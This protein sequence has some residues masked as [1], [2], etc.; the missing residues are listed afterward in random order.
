MR[1]E[2]VLNNPEAEK[3]LLD[4]NGKKKERVTPEQHRQYVQD[5]LIEACGKLD[6]ESIERQY[7]RAVSAVKELTVV[8]QAQD[9]S[10]F[11]ARNVALRPRILGIF[12]SALVNAVRELE[13]PITLEIVKGVSLDYFGYRLNRKVT[14]KGSLGDNT[15]Y[16]MEDGKLVVEGDCKG[17]VGPF[18]RGGTI[19]VRGTIRDVGAVRHGGTITS[20]RNL[21][22]YYKFSNTHDLLRVIVEANVFQDVA[23]AIRQGGTIPLESE[24]KRALHPQ[25]VTLACNNNLQIYE[26][27]RSS[28]RSG[29]ADFERQYNELLRQWNTIYPK[30]QKAKKDAIG[31]GAINGAMLLTPFAPFTLF[32]GM[33]TLFTGLDSISL[34]AKIREIEPKIK[35]LENSMGQY[36]DKVNFYDSKISEV[37]EFMRAH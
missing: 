24:M 4:R 13:E 1:I 10:D 14:V 22:D 11:C 35:S 2:D 5:R 28:Y 7:Q 8:P 34:K 21:Q 9:I 27:E 32:F 37:R 20:S 23:A 15:A 18:M 19:N 26:R 12:A 25:L 3:E 6:L 30:Y 31:T 36:R 16:M 29:L 17:V 33:I